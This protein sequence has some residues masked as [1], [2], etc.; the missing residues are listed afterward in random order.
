[1]GKQSD[2]PD[3][4]FIESKRKQLARLRDALKKSANAATAEEGQIAGESTLQAREYEDDAQR[5]D[6]LEKEG[7][8]VSRA[9]DRLIQVERAL[10]KIAEGTYGFSDVSGQRIADDRLEA[11]PEAVTTLDEQAATEKR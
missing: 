6:T 10:A 1:M 2:G 4:A 11:V 5:L 9:V 8:L 7:I 3:A